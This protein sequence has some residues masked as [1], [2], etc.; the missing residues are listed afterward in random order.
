MTIGATAVSLGLQTA[1]PTLLFLGAITSLLPDIDISVSPAG[2]VFPWISRWLERRFPH[3]SCTHSFFASFIVAI[4]T[5]PAATGGNV[6]WSLLHAINIGYFAG[7]FA[8]AFTRSGVEM[9]YPSPVRWAIPGNRNL[10]LRTG[11]PS[12]YGLLVLLVAIALLSFNINANGG[13]LTQFNRL[14]ASTSGVEQLYNELG[15]NHLMVA[16]IKGVRASDR[17][18]VMGDFWIIQATGQGFIV[19]SQT[20]E[21]Y[22]A[23][24]EPDCQL[25]A[26]HIT[27]DP[28]PAATTSMEILKLEE[29]IVADKLQQFNRA[30]AMVFISGQLTID[31]PEGLALVI[32]PYQFQ[33]I[34][35]S[36]N[37]INLEAAP[38]TSVQQALG[39]QFATGILTVKSIYAQQSKISSP[40][41]SNS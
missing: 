34:R 2:R 19:E 27:A 1:N 29:E 4:A 21:I 24:T 3:R 23:G 32:D 14:I 18:P 17:A 33:T 6:P 7:W 9:F 20:G 40:L 25:I 16:H 37:S 36:S 35:A 12:E 8:D 38:L 28:G 26:E 13:I 5:Y 15:S 11:S 30:G 41:D 31:D 10:R 22:K 39:E